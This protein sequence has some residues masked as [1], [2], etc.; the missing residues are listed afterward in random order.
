LTKVYDDL[1]ILFAD[2]TRELKRRKHNTAF[3]TIAKSTKFMVSTPI[4]I[5]AD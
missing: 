4:K 1:Y 5:V 3:K 2:V